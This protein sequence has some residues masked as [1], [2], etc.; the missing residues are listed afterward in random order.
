MSDLDQFSNPKSKCKNGL[1]YYECFEAKILKKNGNI[2]PSKCSLTYNKKSLVPTCK[3]EEE[4]KCATNVLIKKRMDKSILHECP[5][6]CIGIEY[7]KTYKWVGNFVENF[8]NISSQEHS[9]WFWFKIEDDARIYT[10][11]LIYDANSMIGSIGGAL[12]LFIGFSFSNV[13]S[14]VV[15]KLRNY[16]YDNQN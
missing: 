14:F 7:K 1:K 5:R 10:E 12:G 15:N 2:C 3:T 4:I 13:I 16:F 8:F 11:Y 6:S 9:F